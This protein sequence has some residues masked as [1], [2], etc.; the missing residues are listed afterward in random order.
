[1]KGYLALED[2]PGSVRKL[3]PGQTIPLAR[4]SPA[5]DVDALIG[6]FRPLFRALGPDQVN[7]LVIARLPVPVRVPPVI[8]KLL[9]V[10]FVPA[11]SVSVAEPERRNRPGPVMAATP[12]GWF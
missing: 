1:M 5:L 11:L 4:T 12:A 7:A 9:T 2:A 3:Q 8:S 10:V 6:G